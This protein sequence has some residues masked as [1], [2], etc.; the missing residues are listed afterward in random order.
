YRERIH[1]DHRGG[2]DSR[3]RWRPIL[4][5]FP[6]SHPEVECIHDIRYLRV[7]GI[8]LKLDI[9]R[10][11]SIPENCPTLM[12]VHGG[13]WVIGSRKEQ[14]LPLM[15][16]MASRGWCCISV[17]YRLS[18]HATFPEHLIDLKH[19]IRWI[20]EN[21]RQYGAN[22]DFLVVTGGSA[23][24][25]LASLLALTANDPEYQPGFKDIDTSVA[26]CV[27]FYGIYD[28][29]DREGRLYHDGMMKLLERKVMKAS[30]E[31]DPEAYRKASPVDRLH[32]AA[33]PFFVIHG[34]RDTL[35]PVSE[36]R[37]FV[38][39]LQEVSSSPVAYAEVPGGQHA[40]DLFP[41]LRSQAVI[42]AVDRFLSWIYS[43]Y[44]AK[45]EAAVSSEDSADRLEENVSP[46]QVEA[47]E[48][49][50][51]AK[52]KNKAKKPASR[53]RS[54]RTKVTEAAAPADSGQAAEAD[55][56]AR[57]QS[58]PDSEKTPSASDQ[59]PA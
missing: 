23:G 15:N 5:P 10:H 41:S 6:I 54:A 53:K 29:T 39:A 1:R 56:G 35:A 55:G 9:Y 57:E 36:A 2:F 34:D 22:P 44:L 14:G 42:D 8:D 50:S 33:P 30:I 31:E 20:K 3:I 17:S 59:N 32:E 24:G 28:F 7:R 26:G 48:T 18:P 13:G 43:D 4:K 45:R 12:Q 40:F 19:A 37:A 11:R 38:A 58:S 16:Q 27:P 25:H 47:A 46:A 52:A 21:G 49:R 51:P